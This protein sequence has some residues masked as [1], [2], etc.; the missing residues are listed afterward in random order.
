MKSDDY[1]NSGLSE[2]NLNDKRK[3]TLSTT[4]CELRR[5]KTP[6]SKN[7]PNRPKLC[8]QSPFIRFPL[9]FMI[10]CFMQPGHRPRPRHQT[11]VQRDN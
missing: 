7:K 9:L 11:R 2:Y 6:K 10:R 5:G 8:M 4:H 1:E 3:T